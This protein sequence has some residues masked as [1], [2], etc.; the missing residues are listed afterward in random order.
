[1]VHNYA[2]ICNEICIC[3]NVVLVLENLVS[4][5]KGQYQENFTE[6]ANQLFVWDECICRENLDLAIFHNRVL[7]IW[8]DNKIAYG[9]IKSSNKITKNSTNNVTE[10]LDD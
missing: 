4:K 10:L 8:R 9:I 6:V 5:H 2:K 3:D 1:M 7:K